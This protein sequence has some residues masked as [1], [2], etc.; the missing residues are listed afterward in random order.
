MLKGVHKSANICILF[1]IIKVTVTLVKVYLLKHE[2]YEIYALWKMRDIMY[3]FNVL[4][5]NMRMQNIIIII[6]L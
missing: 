4:S 3:I 6:V 1:H 5:L 2:K